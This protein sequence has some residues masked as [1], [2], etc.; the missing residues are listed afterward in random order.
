MWIF[1]EISLW[2]KPADKSNSND[3]LDSSADMGHIR[4][5]SSTMEVWRPWPQEVTTPRQLDYEDYQDV[6][7]M[8]I[9][10]LVDHAEKE[11][12]GEIV[13]T[14]FSSSHN[15]QLRSFIW[16][17]W[18]E[19]EEDPPR[20]YGGVTYNGGETNRYLCGSQDVCSYD[21][22]YSF[23]FFNRIPIFMFCR[24]SGGVVTWQA[25]F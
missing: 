1:R 17:Y 3:V 10:V 25:S 9:R 14:T 19:N 13:S 2:W 7:S 12:N 15:Q 22:F 18:S 6:K 16:W 24:G 21:T 4:Q 5:G 8:T 20:T 11:R 23:V